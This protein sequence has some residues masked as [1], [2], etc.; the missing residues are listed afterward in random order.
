MGVT[1]YK[2]FFTR[3]P[4][5]HVMNELLRLWLVRVQRW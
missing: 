5:A 1:N 4:R 3:G 2:M